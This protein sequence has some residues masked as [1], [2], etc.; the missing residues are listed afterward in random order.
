[1]SAAER[2]PGLQP[3]PHCERWTAC[4]DAALDAF[5]GVSVYVITGVSQAVACPGD[6]ITLTGTGFGST[7]GR[8]SFGGV[9]TT[10]TT[11]TDISIPVTVPPGARNPLS[12]VLP[13][14]KRWICGRLVEATPLG[15]ITASFEVGIPEIEALFIGSPWNRPYCVEPGD[16][17][18]LSWRVRGT[19]KVVVEVLD[20]AGQVVVR[21]DPAPATGSSRR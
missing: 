1:V 6:V 19:T 14:Y 13:K 12:L 11:W 8:V 20:A 2:V 7:P 18:P 4:G 16:P 5:S 21:S 15:S 3:S 9:E 10:A 17:I